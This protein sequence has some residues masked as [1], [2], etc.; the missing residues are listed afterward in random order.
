MYSISLE[1]FD[2]PLAFW[3]SNNDYSQFKNSVPYLRNFIELRSIKND[4][5]LFILGLE[6]ETFVVT[7][8]ESD[9][10]VKSTNKLK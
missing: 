8:L 9:C 6:C 3:K 4:F 7:L 1:S 5:L 2:Y 10:A